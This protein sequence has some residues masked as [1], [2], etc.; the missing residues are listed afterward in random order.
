MKKLSYYKKYFIVSA[1]LNLPIVSF[2][3]ALMSEFISIIPLILLGLIVFLYSVKI[4]LNEW[5]FDE[6]IEELE[7][8][9]K[10][11]SK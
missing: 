1:I 7:T 2:I 8:K 10:N 9:I 11:L 5:Y 6:K 4:Q 3:T